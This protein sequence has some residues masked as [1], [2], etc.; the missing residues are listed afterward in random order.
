MGPKNFFEMASNVINDKHICQKRS[1]PFRILSR[2][3]FGDQDRVVFRVH[4]DYS[5]KQQ[6]NSSFRIAV[7]HPLKME[8][9]RQ[10]RKVREIRRR[11]TPPGAA[12]IAVRKTPFGEPPPQGAGPQQEF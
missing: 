4:R 9:K 2:D 8:G 1:L 5:C 7:Y 12:E 3:S 10:G 11:Q 6:S